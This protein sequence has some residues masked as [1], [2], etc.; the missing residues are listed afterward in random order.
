MTLTFLAAAASAA[1]FAAAGPMQTVD[2]F[3][4]AFNAGNLKAAA[5][6][7]TDRSVVIDDFPPHAWQGGNGCASW[8]RDFLAYSANN[9]ATDQIVTLGKPSHVDVTADRAY[10]VVPASYAYKDHG[11][12]VKQIGSIFTVALQRVAGEWRIAGFAWADH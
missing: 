12:P 1:A 7:C 4:S 2:Q 3:V 10:V 9:E 11:K 8:A 6:L 5:A